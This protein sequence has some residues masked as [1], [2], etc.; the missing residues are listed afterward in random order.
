[1]MRKL[2][3]FCA[4]FSMLPVSLECQDENRALELFENAIETMGGNAFLNVQ[5]IVSSG[6]YFRFDRFGA[7][8]PLIKFADYT[9]L[10]DKSRNELGNKKNQLEITVFNLG[11]NEGWILEGRSETREANPEEMR[12]FRNVVK[13]S[14]ELI[15][16]T[17]YKDPQNRIFYLGAGEG[18]DVRLEKVKLI[19]PENDE[20]TVYFDRMSNLP[21]KIEYTSKDSKGV[22]MRVRQEFSQWHWI[23][24]VRASLRTDGYVNGRLS[25]QS[26]II[27]IKYNNDLPD[28][29]FLKPVPPE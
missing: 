25:F 14:I 29:L 21:Q 26:H 7:S 19:D 18:R 10:P 9:K 27:E 11:K 6:N 2:L 22:R 4:F 12:D 5:D 28:S 23:Q 24:G 15:F 8:S 13:H 1:M 3:F 16:R 17:R 20:V